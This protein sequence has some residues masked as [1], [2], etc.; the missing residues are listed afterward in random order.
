MKPLHFDYDKALRLI[1]YIE[2]N[3]LLGVQHF[4]FYNHTVGPHVECVLNHYLKQ[5]ESPT[6]DVLEWNLDLRSQKEIRTEGLLAA[7]N[8]CLYRNMYK[9]KYLALVDLDEF[10]IPRKDYTLNKLM[11]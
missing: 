4:T 11:E 10:I 2:L 9:Y 1:E 3:F 5:K 7:L 6:V 8:D